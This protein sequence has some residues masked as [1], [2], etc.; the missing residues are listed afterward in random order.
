MSKTKILM[1]APNGM[2]FSVPMDKAAKVQEAWK[3]QDL[4][5][6]LTKEQQRMKEEIVRQVYG[7]SEQKR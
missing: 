6:P 7:Q 2:L 4:K 1:E 5:K 3:H